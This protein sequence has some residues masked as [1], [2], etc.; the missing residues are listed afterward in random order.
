MH[1]LAPQKTAAAPAATPTIANATPN[2]L[3]RNTANPAAPDVMAA[4]LEA[5]EAL[6]LLVVMDAAEL[7]LYKYEWSAQFQWYGTGIIVI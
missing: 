5:A 6:A 4:L 1:R 3:G 7:V 2:I